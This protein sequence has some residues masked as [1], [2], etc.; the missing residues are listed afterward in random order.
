MTPIEDHI[1]PGVNLT[2]VSR[3]TRPSAASS[4]NFQRLLGDLELSA[5]TATPPGRPTP[6]IDLTLGEADWREGGTPRPNQPPPSQRR[7]P[8]SGQRKRK[9]KKKR[10]ATQDAVEGPPDPES[11]LAVETTARQ[12]PPV[13]RGA[14][15]TQVFPRSQAFRNRTHPVDRGPARMQVLG[16]VSSRRARESSSE[17]SRVRGRSRTRLGPTPRDRSVSPSSLFPGESSLRGDTQRPRNLARDHRSWERDLPEREHGWL[18]DLRRSG[19]G[20]PR[21]ARNQEATWRTREFPRRN[22]WENRRHE[23]GH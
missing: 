19:S 7:K 18:G 1:A 16:A 15:R 10:A 12:G 3:P 14:A 23:R 4:G 2:P 6:T 13:E 20:G 5:T 8:R 17:R 11:P 21:S 22:S 9:Q